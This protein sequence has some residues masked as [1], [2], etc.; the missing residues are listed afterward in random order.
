[1][2]YHIKNSLG[3]RIAS[4]KHLEDRNLCLKQMEQFWYRC[5]TEDNKSGE[6]RIK[7]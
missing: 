3:N 4:F 5:K 6:K 2:K 7:K 1:M